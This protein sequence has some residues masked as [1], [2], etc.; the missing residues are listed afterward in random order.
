[1]LGAVV[2]FF[3]CPF[4][5]FVVPAFDRLG[6]ACPA[7]RETERE[8]ERHR[9][10]ERHIMFG[11]A[12]A[13]ILVAS[14]GAL[15]ARANGS[16]Y[17]GS[18]FAV[19]TD[20]FDWDS[21]PPASHAGAQQASRK[22]FH[23]MID[24]LQNPANCSEATLCHCHYQLGFAGLFSKIHSRSRC[25]LSAIDRNCTLYDKGSEVFSRNGEYSVKR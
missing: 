1:M 23:D 15:H 22:R 2:F 13:L 14:V 11:R 18:T 4:I 5:S 12:V 3:L 10:T 24:R 7:E 21:R 6:D 19:R 25:L 20:F 9:E 17:E 8:G 16:S